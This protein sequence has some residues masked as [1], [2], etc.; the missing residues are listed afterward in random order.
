MSELAQR[1]VRRF[2]HVYVIRDTMT[3]NNTHLSDVYQRN[4]AHGSRSSRK[5]PHILLALGCAIALT[6]LV[7][8]YLQTSLGVKALENLRAQAHQLDVIDR[9]QL[10]LVNAET[11]VRGYLLTGDR[12]FLEPYNKTREQLDETIADLRV[13]FESAGVV[14]VATLIADVNQ[15]QRLMAQA[16]AAEDADRATARESAEA[17]KKAMDNI[18]MLTAKLRHQV[19]TEG[20]DI[21]DRSM[22]RFQLAQYVSIALAAGTLVLLLALVGILQRQFALRE[23]I[24]RLLASENDRLEEQVKRRTAEL[25]EL[26]RMIT[27]AREEEKSRLARELHDEMGALLTAAK[28]DASWITRKL[29]EDVRAN[30][31]SRLDRLQKML[32]EG[33]ALKRRIIDDLRPP[34][35]AEM[36]LIEAIR[37]L[38]EDLHRSTGIKV[39]ID[40][41]ERIDLDQERGLAVFRI[42]QEAITNIRK[43]AQATQVHLT[44]KNLENAAR[45]TVVD[46]GAGFDPKQVSTT[47]H[48]LAGMRHRVKTYGGEV[49]LRSA[50]G[51]GT[52]IS[53]VI[54]KD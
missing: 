25:R 20:H 45:L 43:Y 31:Q 37:A 40:V 36:G 53:A 10:Q 1:D 22:S 39:E 14:D 50:P 4:K 11:G 48:G 26:A 47:R 30:F 16:V 38:G 41:P 46:N 5:W 51:Q 8:N 19:A 18:R 28:M 54:P 6:L 52:T 29:P 9:L 12:A 23:R 33:I 34:L 27:N 7:T 17:G 44:L 24:S 21:L 2:L 35:L 13:T 3:S 42:A 49:T 15:H 32:T